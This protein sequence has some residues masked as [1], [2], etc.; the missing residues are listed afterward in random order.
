MLEKVKKEKKKIRAVSNR[1][2]YERKMM[3][4]EILANHTKASRALMIKKQLD[5]EK[6]DLALN[7][8]YT[9]REELIHQHVQPQGD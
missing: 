3:N 4:D 6:D 5:K 1:Y 7:G 2:E 9:R 8:Y